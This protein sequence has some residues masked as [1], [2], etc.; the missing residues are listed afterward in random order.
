M[1]IM[2]GYDASEKI[3]NYQRSYKMQQPHIIACTGHTES[4]YVKKAWSHQMDEI[5]PKPAQ[6]DLVKKIL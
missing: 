2:N 1:P 3:R 4:E 6:I 5:I